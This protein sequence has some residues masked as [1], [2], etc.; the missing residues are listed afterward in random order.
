MKNKKTV[1]A[2]AL[3]VVFIAVAVGCWLAFSPKAIAGEKTITVDVTHKNG[4]T[5]TFTLHTTAE[6]LGD[7][8]VEEGL[9][10][11]TDGPYGMYIAAVD[12]EAANE[13]NQ[14]WWGYTKSGEYVEYG[15]DGCVIADGDHYEFTFNI[16]W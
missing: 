10:E 14:E 9:L 7:A 3:M 8:M 15:V 4:E 1:I 16:G 11:G 13:D 2:I 5:G 6:Y 12:G